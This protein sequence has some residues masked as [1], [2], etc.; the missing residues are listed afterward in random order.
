L[1]L[2]TPTGTAITDH[3]YISP[4]F[5]LIRLVPGNGDIMVPGGGGPNIK[6]V[7]DFT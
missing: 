5:V 7:N 6:R 1:H 4:R 2:S 3:S